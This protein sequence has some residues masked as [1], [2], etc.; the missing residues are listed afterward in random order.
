M[1]VLVHFGTPLY[2]RDFPVG[3]YGG[4]RKEVSAGFD[5]GG[6]GS[7]RAAG[8]SKMSFLDRTYP[9]LGE[10]EPSPCPPG[11][12]GAARSKVE[13]KVQGLFFLSYNRQVRTLVKRKLVFNVN[14]LKTA[15]KRLTSHE[16]TAPANRQ[17]NREK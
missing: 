5:Q 1:A 9:I 14:R 3:T 17:G 2:N 7:G 12:P 15:K 4:P 8:G 16:N 11:P 13:Q 10:R 6:R